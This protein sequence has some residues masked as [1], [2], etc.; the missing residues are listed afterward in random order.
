[1]SQSLPPLGWFRAFECAARHLSFT[2][3]ASELNLT[4]SAISQHVRALEMRFGTALFLRKARGL[5]LTDA[6]RRLL[7][8]ATEAIE[9]LTTATAM[10]QGPVQYG[11]LRV[12]CTTSFA[13]LWM[14]PRLAGFLATNAGI[15]VQLVSTLWPEDSSGAEVDLEIRYGLA[16]TSY[17]EVL[18]RR[19]VLVPVCAPASR[20]RLPAGARI[21]QDDGPMPFIRTVGLVDTWGVW[22]KSSGRKAPTKFAHSVDSHLLAIEMARAGLGMALVCGLLVEADI[23]TGRLVAMAS[24]TVPALEGYFVSAARPYAAGALPDRFINWLFAQK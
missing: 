24:D 18:L 12:A 20:D 1:M 19:D 16:R 9:K 4:Q 15:Q 23:E 3:A 22:G 14:I 13:V 6:G 11:T 21:W 10:F 17:S 5:A 2:A 7:P 8:H